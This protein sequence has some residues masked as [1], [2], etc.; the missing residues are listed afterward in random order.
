[1]EIA[2]SCFERSITLPAELEEAQLTTEYRYG[3]LLVHVQ[4]E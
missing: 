4:E 2:Y 3:L 1:M